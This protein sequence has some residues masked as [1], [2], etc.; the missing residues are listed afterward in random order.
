MVPFVL[1]GKKGKKK[2]KDKLEINLPD[3]VLFRKSDHPPC[4]MEVCIRLSLAVSENERTHTPFPSI[5]WANN[6]S[7]LIGKRGGG[8]MRLL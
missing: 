1:V 5:P 3:I 7:Q 4:I 6:L 2:K 8:N